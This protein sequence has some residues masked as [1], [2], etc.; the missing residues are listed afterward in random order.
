MNKLSG[1][2][3]VITGGN[4]GIGFATAKLFVEEGANVIIVGRREAA[5]K[6]AVENL[7]SR[8]LGVTGDIAELA[9]HEKVA[10]LATK[11]FGGIDIYVANAGIITL[12]ATN[13][14]GIEEYDQQFAINTRGVFFGVQKIEHVLRNGGSI[15]LVSSIAAHKVLE[16]HA[17]YAGTKAAI[18]AFARN[19]AM[20]FKERGIRVNIVSPGPTQTP[21]LAKIG[22]GPEAETHFANSIPLGR[23]GNS[24]ELAGAVLFF[25]SN[26][27]SFIT[28]A[29]LNV[30]GGFTLV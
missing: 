10:A 28:G 29:K 25:A 26:E 9:T 8:A 21:I 11:H 18:E 15:V 20:E 23:M 16:G 3:A 4:S 30:D 14:V 2:V 1:K 13:M 5:V 7:G 22:I 19:W 12:S 17:V 24:D 27:S 6:D